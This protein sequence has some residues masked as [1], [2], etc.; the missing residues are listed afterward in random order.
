MSPKERRA[1]RLGYLRAMQR[2][3]KDLHA[4]AATFDDEIAGL[5]DEMHGMRDEFLRWRA[6]EKAIAAERDFDT[7]LH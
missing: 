1:Y 5:M 6:V 2:A 4:L 7:L 3:R